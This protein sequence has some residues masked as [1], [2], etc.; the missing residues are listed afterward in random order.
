MSEEHQQKDRAIRELHE[1]RLWADLEKLVGAAHF[2][3]SG[4]PR[5]VD[6][7]ERTVVL[8]TPKGES[9]IVRRATTPEPEPKQIYQALRIPE[10]IMEPVK[11]WQRV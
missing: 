5:L 1:R 9:L 3:P 11:T 4:A 7:G 8:P 10:T 2:S 6:P